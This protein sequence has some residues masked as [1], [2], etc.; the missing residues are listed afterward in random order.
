MANQKRKRRTVN[1][2]SLLDKVNIEYGV[3]L[4]DELRDERKMRKE[5]GKLER[6]RKPSY[7][8]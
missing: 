7:I 3:L 6:K 5:L 4:V 2:L 8:T 1:K